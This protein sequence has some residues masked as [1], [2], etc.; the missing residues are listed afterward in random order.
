M[1]SYLPNKLIV[2]KIIVFSYTEM[3][4]VLF[5]FFIYF[6][7]LCYV[8]FI[9]FVIIDFLQNWIVTII[10]ITHKYYF[11]LKINVFFCIFCD[12]LGSMFRNLLDFI[13]GRPKSVGQFWL[14][15]IKI[16]AKK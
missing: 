14:H 6:S 13:D 9:Y 3:I 11:F 10:I 1:D 16:D 8:I 2:T 5:S 7:F 12:V 15:T 4:P